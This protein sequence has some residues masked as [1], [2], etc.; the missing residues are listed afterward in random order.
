MDTTASLQCVV[1]GPFDLATLFAVATFYVYSLVV[2][3]MRLTKGSR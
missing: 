3:L 2:I 1:L